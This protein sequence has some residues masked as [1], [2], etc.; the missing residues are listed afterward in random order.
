[1]SYPIGCG[2]EEKE[3][4]FSYEEKKENTTKKKQQLVEFSFTKD[5]PNNKVLN[6]IASVELG[7]RDR[8]DK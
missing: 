1:L 5:R 4:S 3:R 8:P 6:T 7:T 2:E